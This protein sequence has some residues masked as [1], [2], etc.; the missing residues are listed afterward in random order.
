MKGSGRALLLLVAAQGC[1]SRPE[2]AAPPTP[3][4][5]TPPVVYSADPPR[6]RTDPPADEPAWVAASRVT[7]FGKCAPCHTVE[8]GAPNGIGPNLY[9][10]FGRRAAS[11]PLYRYSPSLT[12][13]GL[14]WDFTTL[15]RFL[16][17]PRAVVPGSKMIFSGLADPEQRK[18]VI[19]FLKLR[20][21]APR[22]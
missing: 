5:V 16:A 22:Q 11:S 2:P 4:E 8:R 20:S 1:G 10:V 15:D 18:A 6:P 7:Q 21:E 14:V 12:E 9:N 17:N 3:I 19:A 13:S